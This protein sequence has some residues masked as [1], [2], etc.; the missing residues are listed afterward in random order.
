MAASIS[1][2]RKWYLADNLSITSRMSP[3]ASRR[4]SRS[5]LRRSAGSVELKSD[6][7]HRAGSGSCW[8]M[9]RRLARFARRLLLAGRRLQ[10][11]R[12]ALL[13]CTPLPRQ[14]APQRVHEID[15]TALGMAL[16][17]RRHR[18]LALLLLLDQPP[19]R[20][21]VTI[22]EVAG[23]EGAGLLVNDLLGD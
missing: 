4:S 7:A 18:R 8:P 13:R 20:L 10:E 1:G 11:L 12:G 9:S 21:L 17:A 5:S 15:H 16:G 3:K 23:I 19:Q 6:F 14:A 2:G 22:G